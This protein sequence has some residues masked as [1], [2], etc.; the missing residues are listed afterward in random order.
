MKQTQ[1][2]IVIA[3]LKRRPHSYAEMLAIYGA[4][5]SPWRR[6]V[7]ALDQP[8][9]AK[10]RLDI[11]KRWVAGHEYLTTWRVVKRT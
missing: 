10:F 9:H 11:G 8:R 5:C 1:G 4:G 3:A 2:D 6:C 7:E